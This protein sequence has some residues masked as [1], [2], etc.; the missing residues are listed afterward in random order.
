MHDVLFVMELDSQ[1]KVLFILIGTRFTVRFSL[2]NNGIRD[3]E[4][5]LPNPYKLNISVHFELKLKF[6]L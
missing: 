2:L 6:P 5:S 1:K 3:P 4:I